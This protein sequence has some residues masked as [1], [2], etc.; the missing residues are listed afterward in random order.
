M[1]SFIEQHAPDEGT[2]AALRRMG[3]LVATLVACA[4]A[5]YVLP[6]LARVRPWVRGEGMPV[7]R[8]FAADS[9][10]ELPEFEGGAAQA[11][12]AQPVARGAA[13]QPH[14]SLT[15]HQAQGLRAGVGLAIDPR[16]YEGV[17]QS[18][19]HPEALA[20]F[21]A[22]L[23]RTAE[24]QVGAVT[25]IAHYGDSAIAADEITHTLRRKLQ[26]RFGDAGHGFMLVAR[27]T[28]HYMHR[29]IVHRESDGWEIKT[30]VK[31]E[32]RNG[33]YGYGGVLARAGAGQHATFGTVDEA[34]VGRSVSR[35]ELA[36]QKY[37][38]GG[39]VRVTVD[40]TLVK[41]LAT[42]A[43]SV[44][45]AW[46]TIDVPEG[47]HLLS[48]RPM[49][50]PAHL[51]GVVQERS[52]AGV[53][54]DSLGLVGA[55]ADRLLNADAAHMA[56]QV[57]HRDPDLLV[58]GFGGNEAGNE[59][60][61]ATRYAEALARV[62]NVMRAGKPAM[63]CLLFA[64]L[65]QG[66]RNERGDV[67]TLKV[68]PGIVEAQRRVAK[69]QG[70]AYFDTLAAMGGEGSVARW[71]KKR[72]RLISSDFRHAT[73]EGYEVIATL[74]YKALLKGFAQYLGEP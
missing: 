15:A 37:P 19:E 67:V 31:R 71:Y 73:P 4:L 13:T 59:W 48:L 69:Q 43:A 36:Y 51:Y 24:E 2:R 65:D 32:V 58:L 8:L 45:D 61:D 54:Y 53:V 39:D 12:V 17:T 20:S 33:R 42:R 41:T 64:P 10:A 18:I 44:E 47:A 72:P 55:Q 52:V 57:A 7:V 56:A 30:V 60:L 22:A 16:E 21:Y 3:L 5:S 6:G 38:G 68:L 66:E 9:Q 23:R 27:G 11:A 14:V 35:F 28:M 50:S 26:T 25:R 63:A 34:L 29:D 74:Y 62:V 70:C 40:G 1:R 49:G 46:E